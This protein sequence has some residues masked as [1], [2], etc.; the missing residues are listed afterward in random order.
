MR[1][2]QGSNSADHQNTL[3]HRR[4]NVS[5]SPIATNIKIKVQGKLLCKFLLLWIQ[6]IALNEHEKS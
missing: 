6:L 1:R 3:Y 4:I 2:S 5:R